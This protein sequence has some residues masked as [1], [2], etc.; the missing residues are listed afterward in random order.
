MQAMPA[1]ICQVAI[2][3]STRSLIVGSQCIGL[4]GVHLSMIR[5]GPGLLV[6]CCRCC[7][8]MLCI[9]E[10][11]RL[12]GKMGENTILSQYPPPRVYVLIDLLACPPLLDQSFVLGQRVCAMGSVGVSLVEILLEVQVFISF[13]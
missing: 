9:G 1:G 3:I 2:G 11:R 6:S 13:L 7:R 12:V 10:D 5:M 8:C 4:N